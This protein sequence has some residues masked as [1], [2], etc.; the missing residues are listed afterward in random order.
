MTVLPGNGIP[1]RRDRWPKIG[2]GREKVSAE[3]VPPTSKPANCGPLASLREVFRFER[4]RGGPCRTRTLAQSVMGARS[5]ELCLQERQDCHLMQTRENA[6]RGGM[7]RNSVASLAKTP[8]WLISHKPVKNAIR[9]PGR[10]RPAGATNDWAGTDRRQCGSIMPGG[11]AG[12]SAAYRVH[13]AGRAAVCLGRHDQPLEAIGEGDLGVELKQP[14][15]VAA[16]DPSS[17]AARS[18]SN[19]TAGVL[20]TN[21]QSTVIRIRSMLSSIT[22]HNS[23]GLKK[24]PLVVM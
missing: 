17:Q 4:L 16:H 24:L 10:R 1:P 14:L 23:A 22:Q 5:V 2:S 18:L 21:G 7:L 20:A 15:G 12:T 6:G 11:S 19:C 9:S 13:L 3:T 8:P